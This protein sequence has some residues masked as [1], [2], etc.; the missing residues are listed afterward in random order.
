M[1]LSLLFVISALSHSF[2]QPAGIFL[3]VGGGSNK[4]GSHFTSFSF[5]TTALFGVGRPAVNFSSPLLR[6][7]AAGLA[8]A[9]VRVGGSLGDSV[10]FNLTG[11]VPT[12]LPEPSGMQLQYLNTTVWDSLVGLVEFAGL[13][14]VMGVNA[15]LGRQAHVS[16][17]TKAV[18]NSSNMDDLIDYVLSNNQSLFGLELGNEPNCF[19]KS[20]D[21]ANISALQLYEELGVFASKVRSRLPK[22]EIWG[23]DV[24]VTGDVRGQCTGSYWGSDLLGPFTEYLALGAGRLLDRITWVRLFAWCKRLLAL[25]GCGRP[26]VFS[27][28]SLTF[29]ATWV[30]RSIIILS[31]KVTTRAV[32]SSF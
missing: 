29:H 1:L 20:A 8:P 13:D 25:Y 7:L 3:R 22:T 24:S 32:R 6:R 10:V 2:A 4:I 21:S 12:R 9:V 26:P 27:N 30:N 28:I 18:W 16:D 14:L 31:L 11:S 23:P 5:D 17:P 19:N 15:R